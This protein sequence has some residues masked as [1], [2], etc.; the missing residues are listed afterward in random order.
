MDGKNC[1]GE[2][3][4]CVR[5]QFGPGRR[6]ISREGEFRIQG[7]EGSAKLLS[8][9]KHAT[10]LVIYPRNV[11]RLVV[12]FDSQPLHACPVNPQLLTVRVRGPFIPVP[13]ESPTAPTKSTSSPPTSSPPTPGTGRGRRAG[14]FE[15][16]G[17]VSPRLGDDEA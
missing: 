10:H 3:E 7:I 8:L 15:S 5:Y 2:F 11:V 17:H 13:T 6:S 14:V 1:K 4:K 12:S 16:Q 9:Q